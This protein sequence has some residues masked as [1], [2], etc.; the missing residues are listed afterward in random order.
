[1]V[2]PNKTEHGQ[3]YKKMHLWLSPSAQ[4]RILF[5]VNFGYFGYYRN[6]TEVKWLLL[7][8]NLIFVQN[9]FTEVLKP[10]LPKIV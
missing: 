5:R 1:M 6:L 3:P 10:Y 2:K 4:Q 7:K 8:P 9:R